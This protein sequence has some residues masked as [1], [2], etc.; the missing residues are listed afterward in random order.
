LGDRYQSN[1]DDIIKETDEDKNLRRHFDIHEARIKED[2]K[3]L[4]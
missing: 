1:I 2:Y 3:T 4:V